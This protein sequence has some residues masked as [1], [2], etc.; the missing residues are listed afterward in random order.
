MDL[1]TLLLVVAV[2]GFFVWAI[3]TYIPMAPI[4]KTVIIAI[5]V[6]VLVLFVLRSFGANIPNV[7]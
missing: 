4:F 7:L 6:I 2:I 5:A 3:T 1:L